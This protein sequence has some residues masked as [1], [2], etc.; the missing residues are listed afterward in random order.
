M[1]ND[2]LDDF[3]HK[4]DKMNTIIVTTLKLVVSRCKLTLE[5]NAKS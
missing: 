1:N 5:G 3:S 2:L 4:L